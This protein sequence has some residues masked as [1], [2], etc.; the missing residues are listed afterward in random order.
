M[1]LNT[2]ILSLTTGLAVTIM[3]TVFGAGKLFQRVAGQEKRLDTIMA[4]LS[5]N[6]AEI[7]AEIQTMGKTLENKIDS[8]DK[9]LDTHILYHLE[10]KG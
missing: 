10:K 6:K 7:K 1:T 8:Q 3:G 4:A 5:T 2:A 9:K